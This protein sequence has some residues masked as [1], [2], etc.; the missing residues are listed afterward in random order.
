MWSHVF[1]EHSVFYHQVTHCCRAG[2]PKMVNTCLRMNVLQIL[3]TVV[4]IFTIIIA[5]ASFWCYDV[6]LIVS[7]VDTLL[8]RRCRAG[9][10]TGQYFTI[11]ECSVGQ[12]INIQSAVAGFSGRYIVSQYDP[13]QCPWHNCTR[14]TDV[15]ARLC[16][17]R[18]SC[19]IRQD[20]LIYPQ[21]S[22]PALCSAQRDA[23]FIRITFTCITGICMV[24]IL[25][26]MYRT[27]VY[28]YIVGLS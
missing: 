13:L 25:Y 2:S 27:L 26:C 4:C 12:V 11:N 6:C 14:P 3:S 9:I 5:Q 10:P 22:V 16:N 17:G 24:S 20:I 19:R 8:F 7:G 21:R 15:P 18:R 28:I 23:N 1:L